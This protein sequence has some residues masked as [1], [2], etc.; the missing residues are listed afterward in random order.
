M[1]G[2]WDT[3]ARN[4]EQIPGLMCLSGNRLAINNRSE[5]LKRTRVGELRFW[6]AVEY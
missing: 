4:T 3:A 2:A 1:P 5:K 6:G